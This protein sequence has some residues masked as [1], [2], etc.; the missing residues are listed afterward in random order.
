MHVY[1]YWLK[2]VININWC[3]IEQGSYIDTALYCNIVLKYC[4][5]L[6]F[7]NRGTLASKRF[8]TNK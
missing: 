5:T 3:K 2:S 8:Q 7:F 1:I 4:N 6:H